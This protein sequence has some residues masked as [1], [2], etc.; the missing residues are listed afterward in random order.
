MLIKL[1]QSSF[2]CSFY[3]LGLVSWHINLCGL[4]NAKII[5]VEEQQWYYLT[6]SLGDKIVHAFSKRTDL[7]VNAIARM[8]FELVYNDSKVEL[9]SNYATGSQDALQ[10]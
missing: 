3:G 4:F 6:H 5:F 1:Y 8:V 2:K 10:N 7:K 9:V